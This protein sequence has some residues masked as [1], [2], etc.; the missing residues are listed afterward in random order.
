MKQNIGYTK[1]P[2]EVEWRSGNVMDY[3]VTIAGGNGVK[4]KFH[5]LR[6]G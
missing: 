5:V 6:R 1:R 4:I 2:T 3:H